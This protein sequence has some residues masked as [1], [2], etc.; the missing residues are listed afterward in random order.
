M[1]TDA[2]D[3]EIITNRLDDRRLY[4]GVLTRR[5]FAFVVDYIIIAVLCFPVAIVVLLLGLLTLGLGWALFGVMGPAVALIYIWCTLGSSSQSTVGMRAMGIR[6]ERLDG[7]RVDGT[8]AVLHSI[9]FW[10]SVVPLTPLTLLVTLFTDRKRTLHDLV[11]GT[12]VARTD[13]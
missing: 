13:R 9:L 1:S 6:L 2:L 3:G 11:L 12:V 7:G 5:V 10:V 4:D 8:L